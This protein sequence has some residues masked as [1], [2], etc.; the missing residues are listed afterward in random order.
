MN[1]PGGHSSLEG[2]KIAH[3]YRPYLESASGVTAAIDAW[4]SALAGAGADV[5]ILSDS[6]PI[7]E[8]S[9]TEAQARRPA[10]R[11]FQVAHRGTGRFAIP[12]LGALLRRLRPIDLVVVHEGWVF[13]NF[14]VCLVARL[15]GVR[16]AVMP[17][18][19]Y[20]PEIVGRLRSPLWA[21][22]LLERNVL[23]SADFIH[24]FF[25]SEIALVHALA[26]R[27]RCIVAPTGFETGPRTSIAVPRARTSDPIT[28]L[29]FG[30]VDIEHKGLDI[31][32][33]GL[34]EIGQNVS[35][36]LLI[37]GYDYNGGLRDLRATITN[38]GLSDRVT[39]IG[40]LDASKK[41][42]VLHEADL[43]VHPSRWECHSIALLEVLS[44]ELPAAVS[45]SIRIAPLLAATHAAAVVKPT[46]PAWAEA[47][48]S[49]GTGAMTPDRADQVIGR[50]V[51]LDQLRWQS[52]VALCASAYA[53]RKPR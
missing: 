51:L 6:A 48:T 40:Y 4:S 41:L 38:L 7:D 23:H 39:W 13:S 37:G 9:S 11:V 47:I 21:R 17:H 43:Y 3:Y 12:Q 30:R 42:S 53:G 16:Y 22:R 27:A 44:S 36:R 18:G 25:E 33:A 50:R 46:A 19:V 45:S 20:E 5:Q 1:D 34:A 31:L 29:W 24:V 15:A 26:P 35:W 8:V 49:F 2:V 52:V 28:I 14:V 32:L 10:H